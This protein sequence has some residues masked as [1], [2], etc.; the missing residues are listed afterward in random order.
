M[1][2]LDGSAVSP[3]YDNCA[4]V[5]EWAQRSG[6]VVDPEHPAA[7]IHVKRDGVRR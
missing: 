5:I 6:Y 2:R 3:V 1:G 7:G 4:E